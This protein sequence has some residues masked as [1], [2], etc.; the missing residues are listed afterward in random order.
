MSKQLAAYRVVI[1]IPKGYAI[2][3]S[4]ASQ[5]LIRSAIRELQAESRT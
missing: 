5:L 3:D 2:K 4:V 1:P